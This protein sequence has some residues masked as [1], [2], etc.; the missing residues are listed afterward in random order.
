MAPAA[1]ADNA[2]RAGARLYRAR[3]VDTVM[4]GRKQRRRYRE[5]Q[6]DRED[7]HQAV[8]P[9]EHHRSR[10]DPRG[11]DGARVHPRSRRVQDAQGHVH[12]AVAVRGRACVRVRRPETGLE[13]AGPRR[14]HRPRLR[15]GRGVQDDLR[16]QG[17]V[18][19]GELR[20]DGQRG[21]QGARCRRH[22]REIAAE[23]DRDLV[24]QGFRDQ[25]GEGPR[26]KA[27]RPGGRFGRHRDV[28]R[29]HAGRGD[30]QGQGQADH[31]ASEQADL[32]GGQQAGRLHGHLLRVQRGDAGEQDPVGPF[33]LCRFRTPDPRSRA[34]H[35]LR[36]DQERSGPG[37]A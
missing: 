6:A 16:R 10:A 17:D 27:S 14:R 26:R 23:P 28:P 32:D 3:P 5:G 19:R 15:L 25:D 35:P 9:C 18:R 22:R 31:R 24:P 36:H 2:R 20:R 11:R 12:A 13:E 33:P 37:A 29:L 8:V 34:D 1:A 21:L 4:A 7:P 30:R